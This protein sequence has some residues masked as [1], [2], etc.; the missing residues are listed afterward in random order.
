[1]S[2]AEEVQFKEFFS[3]ILVILAGLAILFLVVALMISRTQPDYAPPGMTEAEAA[4]QLVAPTGEVN[5]GGPQIAEGSAAG[6]E[7]SAG[8]GASELEGGAEVYDAV[9]ASCHQ[10]GVAGAPA[11][12]ATDD[13]SERLD[14]QGLDTLYENAINGINAMPPR[15][16]NSALS[17]EQVQQA[18]DYILDESGVEQ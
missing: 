11:T 18:V 15:G 14:S 2:D 9:C 7:E 13:W 3:L 6:A 4:A 12:D 10:G 16:G 8:G 5:M 1:M 17:D